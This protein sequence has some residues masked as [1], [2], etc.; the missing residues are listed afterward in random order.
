MRHKWFVFVEGIKLGVPLHLLIFHDMSKFRPFEWF[1]YARTFYKPDGTGQYKPKGTRFDVAWLY[2]I[3]RNK[4]H[5]QYWILVWDRGNDECF[6]MPKRYLKEMLADWKGA[7][8]AQN[9][10]DDTATWYNKN[11]KNI[12]LHPETRK[13][14]E[15]KLGLDTYDTGWGRVIHH[16]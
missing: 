8:R 10:P 9:N 16:E 6:P 11:K 2:H 4:H 5:W 3:H 13:W 14:L 12:K 1:A 15:V 7:G